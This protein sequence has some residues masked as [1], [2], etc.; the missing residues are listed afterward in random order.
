MKTLNSNNHDLLAIGLKT[1]RYGC[2]LMFGVSA[3]VSASADQSVARQWD[4]RA[5]A[6]IRKDTPHPP[7]Q[8][9]NLFSLSTCMY[10]AWAAY[11]TNSVAFIYHAKH[12]AADVEAARREAISYA[13][14]RMMKERHVFSKTADATLAADDAL[15]A[16]L[17][18]DTN[19][20]SRDLSTP[21][22]VGN[23][24]YDAVSLWFSNDGSRQTNGTPAAPY[25]D[26][27]AGQGGYVYVNQPLTNVLPGI[28]VNDVNHWQRLSIANG[29]DQ[30]GFP[31]ATNKQGYLGAQWLGVRPYALSR[32]DP[33]APWI[34]PGPPPFLGGA[35]DAQFRTEVVACIRASS[36]LTVDDGVTM[37]FSPG[38]FGNNSL[39]ADDGQGHAVNPVTG[40]AYTPNVVKRGDYFRVLA[41]FWADGPS[42][43]T[44]PGHW[45]VLA[46]EVADHPLTV[47]KIGGIGSVVSDL[48]WDVK[49]YFALN[50]SVHDAACA[51]WAIKRYYTGW[52]PIS[53]VRFM[54]QNGQ[55]SDPTKP[56]YHTNGLPLIPDLIEL[57][58]EETAAPGGRHADLEVGKIAIHTWPG[59]PSDP[60]NQTSGVRWVEADSWTTYQKKTFVSPA[61]PGYVSGHSC[62]SRAAAEVMTAITGSPFF[63]GGIGTHSAIA[64]KTLVNEKG[65]SQDFQLQWATYYD[66]ADLAGLSR[67]YGGIHPP[68]DNFA[69]RRAG[70]QAGKGVWELASKYFDGSIGQSPTTLAYTKTGGQTEVR[71]P[72]YRGFFYKLQSTTDLSQQFT[73]EPGGFVQAFDSSAAAAQSADGQAKYFRTVRTLQP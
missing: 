5:L 15:M 33:T 70:A 67:I 57:V 53:A 51:A 9:R 12:T 28:V 42:S 39:V 34:D 73:D 27:P 59:Q 23:S 45:N 19:N 35:S 24:I 17:G 43:E 50:A 36:Q 31:V 11:G 25:P 52:R 40:L 72:T 22:G 20:V 44:P 7:A 1:I 2:L 54:G 65:P 32:I 63:P 58:T 48:E 66:A 46:N 49:V 13:A 71:Y 6:S 62:F 21:A 47:K 3:V 4:E 8:A 60:T 10:D 61:F 26:Y 64:N 55:S 69:G 18:Y 14:W 38:V 16:A 37:D 68:V 30:N 41:E 29:F 56:S